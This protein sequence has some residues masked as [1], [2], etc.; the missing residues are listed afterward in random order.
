[1]SHTASKTN[2]LFFAPVS[3]RRTSRTPAIPVQWQAACW[4][5]LRG[6]TMPGPR[7]GLGALAASPITRCVALWE[8]LQCPGLLYQCDSVSENISPATWKK[9][10][11]HRES[12][13]RGGEATSSITT[14]QHEWGLRKRIAIAKPAPGSALL[15]PCGKQGI[16]LQIQTPFIKGMLSSVKYWNYLSAHVLRTF[17]LLTVVTQGSE[18]QPKD[19]FSRSFY[20]KMQELLAPAVGAA[21]ITHKNTP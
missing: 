17:S 7:L 16:R 20:K 15:R 3:P 12:E 9:R 6:W 11:T 1:M 10:R 4:L 14:L 21:G 8:L 2:T 19:N 13:S 5:S 18:I